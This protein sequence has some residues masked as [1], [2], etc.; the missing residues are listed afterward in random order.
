MRVYEIEEPSGMITPRSSMSKEVDLNGTFV[1]N[2]CHVVN[3]IL[4]EIYNNDVHISDLA[5]MWTY[6][7]VRGLDEDLRHMERRYKQRGHYGADGVDKLYV[8]SFDLQY[9]KVWDSKKQRYRPKAFYLR[10]IQAYIDDIVGLCR[11]WEATYTA[12]H[13]EA[14]ED[15]LYDLAEGLT[16]NQ[17]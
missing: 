17:I 3:K 11:E 6:A 9:W 13:I 16:R 12:D 8:D 4:H 1:G 15:V 5:V 2:V 10:E 14:I 7:N